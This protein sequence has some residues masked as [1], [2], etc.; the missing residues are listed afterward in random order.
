MVE[1]YIHSSVIKH[2]WM[3]SPNEKCFVH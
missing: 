2:D 3:W 1:D